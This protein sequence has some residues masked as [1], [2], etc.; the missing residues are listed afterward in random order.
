MRNDSR[1]KANGKGGR[2]E[3]KKDRDSE[4]DKGRR[5]T[6]IVKQIK[7][8][9]GKK[10]KRECKR[11]RDLRAGP[12][13]CRLARH[14]RR[15]SGSDRLRATLPPT[16]SPL[17]TVLSDNR[18]AGPLPKLMPPPLEGDAEERTH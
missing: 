4:R 13:L 17:M 8:R 12:Q 2:R 9:R 10:N 5:E 16:K 1:K 15:G 7:R 18:P 6:E 11:E 14:Y 3:R